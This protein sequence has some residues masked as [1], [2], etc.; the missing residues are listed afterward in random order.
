M[1]TAVSSGAAAAPLALFALARFAAGFAADLETDFVAARDALAT[2]AGAAL[3]LPA[4]VF[5]MSEGPTPA[6][7]V[8]VEEEADM[9][10]VTFVVGSV[11]PLPAA[12]FPPVVFAIAILASA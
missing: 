9:A 6:E 7:D 5:F 2:G 12:F 11:E 4:A 10:V 8:L 3:A 1:R